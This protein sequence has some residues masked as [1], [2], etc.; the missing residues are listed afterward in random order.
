VINAAYNNADERIHILMEVQLADLD[1][2]DFRL[3]H[4]TGPQIRVRPMPYSIASADLT[5]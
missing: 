2:A 3:G 4:A 5:S 1:S